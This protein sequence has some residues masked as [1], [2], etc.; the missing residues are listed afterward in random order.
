MITRHATV[1]V[2]DELYYNLTGK[3]V[4]QG[5]YHGDISI[6]SDPNIIGQLIF[7]FMAET[8]V[9]E[10]FRSLTVEVTLPGNNP[11]RGTVPIQWPNPVTTDPHRPRLNIR[12]PLLIPT[13]TLRPGR[14]DAKLI[15][16][17]GEI[18]VG[19]PWIMLNPA[20]PSAI[21]PTKPN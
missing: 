8:D 11:V 16:E 10:P 3:A 7:F 1:L 9:S 14:I 18:I 20:S 6:W 19:A 15:H 17:S 5:I 4:L 21:P 13:P 2:A 12:W